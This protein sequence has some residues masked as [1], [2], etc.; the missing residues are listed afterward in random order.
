[1]A[2]PPEIATAPSLVRHQVKAP[3]RQM[4]VEQENNSNYDA[5]M[6]HPLIRA[7]VSYVVPVSGFLDAVKK[8]YETETGNYQAATL[9]TDYLQE[10][11]RKIARGYLEWFLMLGSGADEEKTVYPRLSEL[12]AVIEALEAGGHGNEPTSIVISRLLNHAQREQ[13]GLIHQ[14]VSRILAT[15]TACIAGQGEEESLSGE[16]E[17]PVCGTVENGSITPSDGEQN[18]QTRQAQPFG[19]SAMLVGGI[20]GS[21]VSAAAA[22]ERGTTEDPEMP[23]NTTTPAHHC[24]EFEFPCA[25]GLCINRTQV[26]NKRHDCGEKDV[27]DEDP[28]IC[29]HHCEASGRFSCRTVVGC[30]EQK[31]VCDRDRDC[32]DG[33]DEA[34]PY[35][36][37]EGKWRCHDGLKCIGIDEVCN[38]KKE[39]ADGSDEGPR[40]CND[41]I[42][43]WIQSGHFR[44][45]GIDDAHY[46]SQ[47]NKICCEGSKGLSEREIALHYGMRTFNCSDAVEG[48]LQCEGICEDKT[49]YNYW[50]NSTSTSHTGICLYSDDLCD[51]KQDCQN[52]ADE[53]PDF[54]YIMSHCQNNAF[55][56]GY[57]DRGYS[58]CIPISS[59]CDGYPGCQNGRDENP[60]A[61]MSHK[62]HVAFNQGCEF[63]PKN[64]TSKCMSTLKQTC[65]EA[66]KEYQARLSPTAATTPATTMNNEPFS[67]GQTC[68]DSASGL[69]NAATISLAA[70]RWCFYRCA[71]YGGSRCVLQEVQVLPVFRR[72]I[73]TFAYGSFFRGTSRNIN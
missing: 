35:C 14:F 26:C 28:R 7:L 50:C 73:S 18:C 10:D 2:V 69:S 22:E 19:L 17:H 43:L 20:L 24:L 54:C 40:V 25:N 49:S 4:P 57:T 46:A 42:R 39:C 5:R 11:S 44:V 41:Q 56:C 68:S 29:E 15:E 23:E 13:K 63:S 6:D 58:G 33:S 60:F 45:K 30:V 8:D 72:R 31:Y 21:S 64:A 12:E 52:G 53:A 47:L 48:M 66:A 34:L 3:D 51:G 37:P 16:D 70:D 9:I 67:P 61:C 36:C 32:N 55:P 1:M 27:S 71:P 38:S 65:C 62:L 59:L